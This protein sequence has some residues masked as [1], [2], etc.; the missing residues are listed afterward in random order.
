MKRSAAVQER[1]Q[2][3]V[4]RSVNIASVYSSQLYDEHLLHYCDNK[5]LGIEK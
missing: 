2:G 1:R 3:V 4:L 5:L